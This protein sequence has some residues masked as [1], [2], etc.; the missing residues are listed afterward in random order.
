MADMDFIT[1]RNG[2]RKLY[3][4]V[5]QASWGINP[6]GQAQIFRIDVELVGRTILLQRW[7]AESTQL[8]GPGYEKNFQKRATSQSPGCENGTGHHRIVTFTFGGKKFLMRC[9]TDACLPF[10]EEE[11][12]DPLDKLTKNFNSMNLQQRPISKVRKIATYK[13]G[14][15]S[16]QTVGKLVPQESIIEL[17]TK[18]EIVNPVCYDD[19]YVQLLFAQIS[20]IYTGRHKRGE[21]YT[22]EKTSMDAIKEKA[23]DTMDDRLKL[24]KKLL[25]E[26][27]RVVL[28]NIEDGGSL[29]I[30]VAGNGTLKVLKREGKNGLLPENILNFIY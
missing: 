15:L 5:N 23:G 26:I 13:G 24:L 19:L 6:I 18:G 30:V 28:E 9:T 16:V 22:V 10:K 20:N 8:G 3:R 25:D 2:I 21:F 7:E 4:W 11:D 14:F 17:K 27:Q 29:S 1:D 12:Q